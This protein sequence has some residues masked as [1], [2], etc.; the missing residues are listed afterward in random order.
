MKQSRIEVFRQGLLAGVC[1]YAAV[2][3]FF[4]VVNA[5]AGRPLLYTAALLGGALFYQ[6]RDVSAVV[7]APGPVFAY[8]GVH[9]LLMLVLG[10]FAAWLAELSERGPHFWYIASIAFV[11]VIFHLLGFALP[12]AASVREGLNLWLMLVGGVLA[13]AAMVAYLLAVHPNL[14]RVFFDYQLQDP[15]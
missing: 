5:F 7:V 10:T 4:V 13:T 12:L 15:S 9:L 6:L 14:R 11:F 2:A 1:A 8:N 3:V